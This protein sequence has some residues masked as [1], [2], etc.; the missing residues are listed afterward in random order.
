VTRLL[1]A[2][3]ALV[4]LAGCT[5]SSGGDQTR[6]SSSAR[7]DVDTA[8]LRHLRSAAGVEACRPGTSS[9]EL[10]RTTLPCLGGGRSVDLHRLKGPLVINLFAQWCGPCRGELPYY[11]RLHRKAR[12]Q[13]GVIGVDYLDTQPGAALDLVKDAGVTYPLL[14][15]PAGDL[16]QPFRVRGLPGIVLVGADGKVTVQFRV[17]RSYAELRDLVQQQLDVRVP[18]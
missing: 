14:A 18:A 2:I 13:V 9:S 11:Q 5:A 16:R 17:F 15:D 8:A 12:G 10:P 7:V 4:M 3:C 1:V 6:E